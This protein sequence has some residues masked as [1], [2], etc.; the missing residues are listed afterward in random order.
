M[1]VGITS[2]LARTD[3]LMTSRPLRSLTSPFGERP[4]KKGLVKG[5]LHIRLALDLMVH[6]A[7]M[8]YAFEPRLIASDGA[9]QALMVMCTVKVGQMLKPLLRIQFPYHSVHELS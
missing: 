1:T 5:V 7:G 3:T 4:R 6:A 2:E 9:S 8:C